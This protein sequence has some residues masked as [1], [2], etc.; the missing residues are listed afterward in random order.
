[1]FLY[2]SLDNGPFLLCPT[3]SQGEVSL[4]NLVVAML[5]DNSLLSLQSPL[6]FTQIFYITQQTVCVAFTVLF[7]Q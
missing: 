7:L 5:Q 4:S 1:M 2:I 3:K 6:S